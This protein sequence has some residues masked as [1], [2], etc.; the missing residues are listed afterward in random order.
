MYHL[1]SDAASPTLSTAY[2]IAKV[3]NVEVTDIWPN[4]L[5]VVEETVVVR[6]LKTQI[7]QPRSEKAR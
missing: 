2:A 4:T 7:R 3:L 5:E 1:E 6:R